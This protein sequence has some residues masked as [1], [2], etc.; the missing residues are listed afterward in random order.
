MTESG[1]VVEFVVACGKCDEPAYGGRTLFLDYEAGQPLVIDLDMHATQT[2][3]TCTDPDCGVVS[4]TG[5]LDVFTDDDEDDD[6]ASAKP[7]LELAVE[8]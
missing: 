3:F 1:I 7:G 8:R 4:Y 6:Q 5:D 2:S